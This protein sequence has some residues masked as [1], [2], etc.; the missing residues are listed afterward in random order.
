MEQPGLFSCTTVRL[1][2]AEHA[3][4]MG[5][6]GAAS[7]E[8]VRRGYDRLSDLYRSDDEEPEEYRRW[9]DELLT[10]LTPASRVLDLGYGNGIPVARRLVGAGHSVTGVDLSDRQIDR[11]RRL[12]PGA[13]FIRA[14]IT[15]HDLGGARFDGIVALYSLI[16]LPLDR[17][18]ALIAKIGHAL[19]EGGVVLA[20]V[21]WDAWTGGDPDWL[22][23][24]AEMWWS[25]T[26][27]ATYRRWFEQGGM[28]VETVDHV[29]EG[30][31]MGHA[32]LWAQRL[33]HRP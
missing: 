27:H 15:V 6:Q 28:D 25:H 22:G 20:T 31:T 11:A 21:G 17:Q 2:W 16:H 7:V 14:D 13:T 24:G 32:L 23:G 12:V 30:S 1:H 10:R 26:D 18:Q 4:P 8:A 19:S 9:T 29:A 5:D 33:T 3:V